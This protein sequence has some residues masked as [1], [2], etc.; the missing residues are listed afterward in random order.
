M[1]SL[2][3][4]AQVS[5]VVKA[6][7]VAAAARRAAAQPAPIAPTPTTRAPVVQNPSAPTGM[8]SLVD[9]GKQNNVPV[10]WNNQNGLTIGSNTFAPG[11]KPAGLTYQ[12]G[13]YY[14][15]NAS[16]FSVDQFGL[17]PNMER[18]DHNWASDYD[19]LGLQLQEERLPSDYRRLIDEGNTR[20]GD[21]AADLNL[22]QT[23]YNQDYGTQLAQLQQRQQWDQQ[24]LDYQMGG[25]NL[26]HSS[27][28]N[29]QTNR[30]NTPYGW[31]RNQLST[32][33]DR[34]LAV[35]A[36]A[37][38]RNTRDTGWSTEDLQRELAQK[39]AEIS[40]SKMLLN[41]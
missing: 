8:L 3:N 10:N 40:Q 33:H 24:D 4:T 39:L 13:H 31:Q 25:K 20:S 21:T 17:A 30:L 27:I 2:Y 12:N 6:A 41:W 7:Q 19:L 1:A 11:T 32:D 38:S 22:Q 18:G 26:L 29:D 34:A 5:A 28:M 16:A 36:T 37:L 35:I 14:V 9:W 23:N 15:P